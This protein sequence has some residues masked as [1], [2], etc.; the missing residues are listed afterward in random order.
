M[1]SESSPQTIGEEI[2]NGVTHGIGAALSVAGLVVLVVSSALRGTAWH[3]VSCA[4]FGVSLVLLY[5]AST[6][7][8]AL[9][10]PRAKRVFRILDHASIYL[11]IA[12]TYTPFALVTLRGAW[13]WSIFGVVWGLAAAG[14]VFQSLAIGRRPI[15]STGV[16]ILMGWVVLVAFRPLLHALPWPGFLWL[17]AGGGAY[18]AGVV[19]YAAHAKFAHAVW[20]L[21]VL[22]GSICHFCAVYFYVLPRR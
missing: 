19:F 1:G 22:A 17:L 11:L 13:G 20:H 21:F 14:I 18:T 10:A 15:L 8:H 3:I 6:L 12:G 4:V 5:L 7:Y 9:T 16:Y 2:A